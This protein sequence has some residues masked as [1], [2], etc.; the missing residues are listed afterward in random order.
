MDTTADPESANAGAIRSTKRKFHQAFLVL[1]EAVS[2]AVSSKGTSDRLSP[3]RR[4]HMSGSFY[5]TLAKYGVKSKVQDT[6]IPE[7]LSKS[8]P[9]L[10]AILSRAAS[11]TKKSQPYRL[12]NQTKPILP[13]SAATEYRPSSISSFLS[14]LVTYK[15]ATYANKP[16]AIDAVAAA[17]CGWI[18]DGK[19]RLVCGLCK[20]SWVVVGRNGMTR[21]A[22]HALLEKQR[23]SLVDAHKDGCP[24]KR[25]QC[26]DSIY[27]VPLQPPATMLKEL[28]RNAIA[29]DP[30]LSGIIIMHPLTMKQLQS[31]N[32]I[33]TSLS[34]N[35]GSAS[36]PSSPVQEHSEPSDNAILTAL[37]GWS[38]I[39]HTTFETS[40]RAP[41]SRAS[42]VG[43]TMTPPR[44][45]SISRFPYSPRS[46]TSPVSKLSTLSLNN[47]ISSPENTL[48]CCPLCQRRVGLW[49]FA[50]RPTTSEHDTVAQGT[51]NYTPTRQQQLQRPFDLLKEHRSF[52]PYVARSTVVPSLPITAPSATGPNQPNPNGHER[53]TSASQVDAGK[54]E[55]WQ[56]VLTTVL[57]YGIKERLAYDA[58]KAMV[59]GVK[60]GGG[61]DLLKYVRSLLG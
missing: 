2:S 4:M 46:P 16:P 38:M 1:D 24:W 42:S 48:L 58:V 33:F 8:A 43:P 41:S 32:S 37:F 27:R 15:L 13:L 47:K 35:E 22:A 29:L 9:N 39:S 19:D 17:K 20:S 25:R 40:C 12:G 61:R 34:L 26:D 36:R 10:F 18:N 3:K 59:D 45:P 60:N 7:Q 56:A 52:C 28:K 31:L 5:S 6:K 21:E 49:A 30:L 50:P 44:T 51:A 23:V 11:R 14:R 53:I 54:I 57:R 55:G